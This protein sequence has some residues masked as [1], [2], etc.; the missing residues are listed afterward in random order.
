MIAHNLE[1]E[2]DTDALLLPYL[3]AAHAEEVAETLLARLI[4]GSATPVVE[5]VVK[6]KLHVSLL[7]A[8]GSRQNQDALEICGDV[9]V[10]L[11]AQLR[12][13]K[14]DPTGKSIANFR[15]YV[16]STAYHACVE[17]LRAKFP[18]RTSLTNKLRYLLTHD[19][20]FALWENSKGRLCG[21]R[22]AWR[23]GED[24]DTATARLNDL[25]ANNEI[26][27]LAETPAPSQAA[28]DARGHENL[29]TLLDRLFRHTGASV[30]FDSLALWFCFPAFH[31]TPNFY[32]NTPT[33]NRNRPAR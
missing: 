1:A 31:T 29:P 13:L 8:D 5:G 17:Y 4:A 25:R 24:A 11:T 21:G 15:G 30:E 26:L 18:R 32:G 14:D 28:H 33:P 27:D 19:Q 6:S 16:S 10:A 12:R 7:E 22:A 20:N 3:R 23:G 9:Y 2:P